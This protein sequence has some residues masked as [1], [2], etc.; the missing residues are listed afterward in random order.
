MR[1]EKALKMPK[2]VLAQLTALHHKAGE[3]Y[4][5]HYLF[6]RDQIYSEIPTF[7]RED[8]IQIETACQL[9]SAVRGAILDEAVKQGYLTY[10]DPNHDRMLGAYLTL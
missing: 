3:L 4:S 10:D 6:C 2:E 5:R 8:T 9:I 7:L 1:K